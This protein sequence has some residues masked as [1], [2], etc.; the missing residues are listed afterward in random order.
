MSLPHCPSRLSFPGKCGCPQPP[1]TPSGAPHHS[2]TPS[3]LSSSGQFGCLVR[4]SLADPATQPAQVTGHRLCL[5]DPGF[6]ILLPQAATGYW[7]QPV[8]VAQL[9]LFL[10]PLPSRAPWPDPPCLTASPTPHP[11]PE[12]VG[13]CPPRPGTSQQVCPEDWSFH[14]LHSSIPGP[15]RCSC[16]SEWLYIFNLKNFYLFLF[17]A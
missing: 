8:T 7:S 3:E 12:E 16:L 15:Q 13:V 9:Q 14:H 5:G 4:G 11:A 10:C 17:S 6:S 1:S 2:S